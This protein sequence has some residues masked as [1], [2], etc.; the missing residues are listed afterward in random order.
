MEYQPLARKYRPKL[1]AEVIGQ[2]PVITALQNAIIRNRLHH[3]YLLA[4][5]R[6]IGKTSI[7]RIFARA[8]R[9]EQKAPD[10]S[11]PCN[12]CISCIEVIQGNSTDVLE[13]DGASNNGVDSIRELRESVQYLPSRG[14]RKVYI[15]DEVHML[16]TSAF[17]ALLK[18]LE[19]PPPHVN[20]ILATTDPH[21]LPDT[22][23]SRCQRFDFKR[24]TRGEME[25]QL[26]NICASEKVEI[27][28]GAIQALIDSAEGG[29]RDLLSNLDQAIAYCQG[30]VTEIAVTEVLGIVDRRL[31]GELYEAILGHNVGLVKKSY[32][33]L[34]SRGYDV[35]AFLLRFMEFLKG[36]LLWS[37][38]LDPADG[39]ERIGSV[40]PE[41]VQLLFD[42][43]AENFD[44]VVKSER[45]YLMLEVLLMK[46]AILP[47]VPTLQVL[48]AR[49]GGMTGVTAPSPS[50]ANPT[51]ATPIKREG[52]APAQPLTIKPQKPIA[53]VGPAATAPV[54]T[55]SAPKTFPITVSGFVD[56]LKTQKPIL[57]NLLESA[58]V[59]LDGTNLDVW[60]SPKEKMFFDRVSNK[61]SLLILTETASLFFGK[62]LQ[63]K[64]T[65][66]EGQD[67]PSKDVPD[68]SI[69]EQRKQKVLD[70]PQI[71]A[72]LEILGGEVERVTLV[73]DR[74]KENS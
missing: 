33:D 49:G 29:M 56:K 5:S 16:S 73:S 51:G 53:P 63:V 58:R 3:A 31:V 6:G 48:L 12:K 40:G 45:D 66:A 61:E 44:L 19:E 2:K 41:Q 8:L 27:E 62:T 74:N 69:A 32:Q 14:S 28:M 20:F 35:R 36:Q 46:L 25:A 1:F 7:A 37:A 26:K 17:N 72:A 47:D 50:T 57:G 67:T 21:K 24:M 30:A 4:G 38:G 43:V 18:T 10:S 22:I 11:E 9:C 68:Q 59:N 15:V 70:D 34:Y 64:V 23:L 13:I 55:P 71:K 39:S 52:S 42:V 60:F 54:F 65:I